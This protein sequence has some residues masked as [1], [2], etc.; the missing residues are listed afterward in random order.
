MRPAL[1]NEDADSAAQQIKD[2]ENSGIYRVIP[3]TLIVD[4]V[5]E[6]SKE[7]SHKATGILTWKNVTVTEIA[8]RFY[9]CMF[10]NDV[11][12]PV[13]VQRRKDNAYLAGWIGLIFSALS[14][15]PD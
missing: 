13:H 10:E 6:E 11:Y 12:Y 5:I 15:G 2:I 8:S 1:I 7:E 3:W 9:E 4:S 14:G